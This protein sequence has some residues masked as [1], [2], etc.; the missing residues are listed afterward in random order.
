MSGQADFTAEG[1]Q[2][3]TRVV[4]LPK[5]RSKSDS[6]ISLYTSKTFKVQRKF[7]FFLTRENNICLI[8]V[9]S[10]VISEDFPHK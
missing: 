5:Q 10:G 8:K 3:G 6:S 2:I 7:L 9:I 1:A 4:A